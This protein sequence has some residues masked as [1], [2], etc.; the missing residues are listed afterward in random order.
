MH[1]LLLTFICMRTLH[2]TTILYHHSSLRSVSWQ[3]YFRHLRHLVHSRQLYELKQDRLI[4]LLYFWDIV[5]PILFCIAKEFQ[6]Y[7]Q[8]PL[9]HVFVCEFLVQWNLD[10]VKRQSA[11]N[12][13]VAPWSR[14]LWWW[15]VT[16]TDHGRAVMMTIWLIPTRSS[17]FCFASCAFLLNSRTLLN[18]FMTTNVAKWGVEI[19]TWEKSNEFLGDKNRGWFLCNFTQLKFFIH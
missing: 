5:K 6:Q 10:F 19:L 8:V 1:A 9:E 3:L 18:S 11:P 14:W 13:A 7:I 17:L 12:G 2:I 15:W 16:R 4:A